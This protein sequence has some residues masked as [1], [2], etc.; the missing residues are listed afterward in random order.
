MF[1]NAQEKG[2]QYTRKQPG[3][4]LHLPSD[5]CNEERRKRKKFRRKEETMGPIENTYV[6]CPETLSNVLFVGCGQLASDIALIKLLVVQ[7]MEALLTRI[8]ASEQILI[9]EHSEA[10]NA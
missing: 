7:S 10:T 3:S 5:S 2:K 4:P 1:C 9:K 6:G 8:K